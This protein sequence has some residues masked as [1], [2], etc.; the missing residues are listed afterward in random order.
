M[1][2]PVFS[3]VQVPGGGVKFRIYVDKNKMNFDYYE[4]TMPVEDARHLAIDLLNKAELSE[5]LFQ[6][7][8]P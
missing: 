4:V 5:Y 7:Q 1:S 3:V 2:E 6:K 8:K